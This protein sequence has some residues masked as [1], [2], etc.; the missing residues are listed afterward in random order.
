[1]SYYTDLDPGNGNSPYESKSGSG[2]FPYGTYG[3]KETNS[4]SIFFSK[5][6]PNFC[7]FSTYPAPAPG[8]SGNLGKQSPELLADNCNIPVAGVRKKYISCFSVKKL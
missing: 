7:S 1:M 3:S 4:I 5:I 8:G 2:N 6:L